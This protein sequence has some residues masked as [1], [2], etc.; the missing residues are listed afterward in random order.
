MGQRARLA[1]E[2]ALIAIGNS[3]VKIIRMRVMMMRKIMMNKEILTNHWMQM[4]E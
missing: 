4:N 3:T 1:H 2:I